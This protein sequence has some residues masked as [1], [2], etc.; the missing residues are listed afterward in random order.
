LI[1]NKSYNR[2]G[3]ALRKNQ[4]FTFKLSVKIFSQNSLIP[5]QIF[6]GFFFIFEGVEGVSWPL[7]QSQ[8]VFF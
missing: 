3:V 1:E 5:I 4:S 6:N 7:S 8:S 2:E